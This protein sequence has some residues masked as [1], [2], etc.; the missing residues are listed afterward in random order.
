MEMLVFGVLGLIIGSF[1][2]VVILREE[3]GEGIG[4]RSHCPS[5]KKTLQPLDLIPLISW[6]YL[7]G[8]CRYCSVSIS[9]QYPFV[10]AVTALLF[11]VVS[12]TPLALLFKIIALCIVSLAVAIAV[13]D[14]KTMLIPDVWNYLF[15]GS[16]LLYGLGMSF[17]NVYFPFDVVFAG[18]IVAFPLWGL[19]AYSNGTWMGFGDVKFAV[20]MGGLLG[21]HDGFLALIG[22]FIFGALVSVCVLLPLPHVISYAQR[23]GFLRLS[24]S[25]PRFT[26]KSE[27]P[28][29]PFL[30]ASCLTVWFF[31]L[32]GVN[33]LQLW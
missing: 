28:F 29:G 13:F 27:V 4:G 8:R 22:A 26:I 25:S 32:F 31:K 6:L 2:N 1:L 10:E 14:V 16:A 11:I 24:E 30:I 12:L 21:A 7:R 33:L 19:W 15:A 23:H 20:G 17:Q 9:A 5:C 18:L 3:S